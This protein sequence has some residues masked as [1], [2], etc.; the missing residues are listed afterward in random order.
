MANFRGKI[1]EVKNL[2][3]KFTSGLKIFKWK[4][5]YVSGWGEGTVS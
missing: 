5:S 1:E 3:Q 4:N 2:N